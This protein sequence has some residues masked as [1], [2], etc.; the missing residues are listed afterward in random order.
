MG[1]HRMKNKDKF[2]PPEL[3]RPLK[4]ER[5]PMGGMEEKIVATPLE[6][7][8]LAKRFDLVE[9]FALRGPA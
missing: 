7:E 9:N 6:R 3:S 4:V 1:F 8:A 5:V 2:A